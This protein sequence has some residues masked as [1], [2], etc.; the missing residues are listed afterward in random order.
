MNSKDIEFLMFALNSVN[1]SDR[2]EVKAF[3][4]NS[5][6]V[7]R[8]VDLVDLHGDDLFKV[9]DQLKGLGK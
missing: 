5:A 7:R 6:H 1:S 9:I 8:L 3:R 2:D 4:E